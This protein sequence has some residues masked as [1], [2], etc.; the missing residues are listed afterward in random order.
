[1]AIIYAFVL[2]CCSDPQD[3]S[4]KNFKVSIQR[5]LDVSFPIC[6]IK[7]KFPLEIKIYGDGK[8]PLYEQMTKLGLLTKS[9]KINPPINKSVKSIHVFVYSL[10]SEGKKYY[11]SA[12]KSM[13]GEEVGCIYLGKAK[14]EEI[15]DFTQPS[16]MFGATISRVNFTYS[17]LDLPDWAKNDEISSLNYQ[18]KKVVEANGSPI[19]EH[20]DMVLT[21]KGWKHGNQDMLDAAN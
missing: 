2:I 5:F 9:E 1:M 15:I 14:V 8:A 6:V 21:N 11:Q 4:E 20:A 10:T 17:V 7:Q 18:L 12:G 3:A 19:K 13:D 16:D